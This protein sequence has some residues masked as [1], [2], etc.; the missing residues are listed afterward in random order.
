MVK[1]LNA[2]VPLP[3]LIVRATASYLALPVLFL[4]PL[5]SLYSSIFVLFSS[6]DEETA[7]SCL[8]DRALRL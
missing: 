4:S 5:L 7:S 8:N 6:Y 1:T 2:S 3:L